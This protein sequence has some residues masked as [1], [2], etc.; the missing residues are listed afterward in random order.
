LSVS[1]VT[2]A[3]ATLT[4]RGS[5]DD[6]GVVGYRLFRGPAGAP[7]TSL[8]LIATVDSAR[9]YVATRLRSGTGYT[10]GTVAIDAANNASPMTTTEVTTD[11][12]TDVVAPSP[13][14]SGSVV[15]KAFSSTRLDISWGAAPDADT[16][17]YQLLRDGTVIATVDLPSG[18]RYSDNG[19]APS[20]SHIY[21]VRTID[22]AGNVSSATPGRSGTTLATGTVLITRG[23]YLSNVD[24]TSAIVSWWT[25]LP[26]A[27]V[28]G[29]GEAGVDE[30][31]VADPAGA[32]QHHA[33]T[34]SGLL[35]GKMY[36]YQVG[37]GAGVMSAPSSFPTMAPP[38]ATFTFAAIGDFAGGSAIASRNA[39]NIASSSTAFI[40]TL[41]DNIYP[42]AGMPDPDYNTTYSDF[43]ARFF[44]PFGAAIS[45]QAFFPANGNKEYYS[46]GA[47]WSA[48]PMPGTNHSWYSYNWGD[49]HILVLDSE[50]PISAGTPQHEFAKADLIA[51][52]ADKWL[53]VAMQNP[54]YSSSS[55]TSSSELAQQALVPLF[56][57]QHVDLVLTGN[58]HNYERTHPL[59]GG[60]PAAGGVTYIVSGAG[61]GGF[62]E[63]TIPA[64]AS[65]AF[66]SDVDGE[67]VRVSVSPTTLVADAIRADTNTVLD[68][69]TITNGKSA[70]EPPPNSTPPPPDS[71][72]PPVAGTPAPAAATR[73]AKAGAPRPVVGAAKP[74]VALPL[75]PAATWLRRG[76]AIRVRHG[77]KVIRVSSSTVLLAL[78]RLAPSNTVAFRVYRRMVGSGKPFRAVGRAKPGRRFRDRGLRPRTRYEYV[79]VAIDRRGRISAPSKAIRLT[80]HRRLAR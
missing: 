17:A 34:I 59:V 40:Q 42:S 67:F 54:P 30:H 29:W 11:S 50:V 41:G 35:R 61:G 57:Q 53:I 15:V 65:T 62:N 3:S 21:T 68:T 5:T 60:A 47:F 49:A 79:I 69:T 46:D 26:T 76:V 58:S 71:A 64:P 9:S 56:E 18:L 1:A 78:P 2:A 22:A 16:A 19:L 38:G 45:R 10:F 31:S 25:N 14:T 70:P 33:V 13:P 80:T 7:A 36:H 52:Q 55:A 75:L 39:D 51:H 12:S 74:R 8:R 28:V 24:G 63:F 27:G 48:F 20:T 44:K 77:A 43:D 23:P 72:P 73:P 32:V 4:W 6:V 66:R 37:D